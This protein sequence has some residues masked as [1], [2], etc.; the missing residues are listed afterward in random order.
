MRGKV[1]KE[2]KETKYVTA[3]EGNRGIPGRQGSLEE[4]IPLPITPLLKAG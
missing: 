1:K 2:R 4:T 3:G